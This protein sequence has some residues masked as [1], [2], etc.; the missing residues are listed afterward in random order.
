M[1]T[2]MPDNRDLTIESLEQMVA[3][4]KDTIRSQRDTI[5][6]LQK[7]N[8]V[9][10]EQ[11]EETSKQLES[12]NEQFLTSRGLFNSNENNRSLSIDENSSMPI[13]KDSTF[14]EST[15]AS[16]I[17]GNAQ[18]V[19]VDEDDVYSSGDDVETYKTKIENDHELLPL[20]QG[21]LKK[22][23]EKLHQYNSRYVVLY[24]SFLLYYDECPIKMDARKKRKNSSLNLMKKGGDG[25]ND[26][27]HP[28][29]TIYLRNYH[30]AI[31]K[32]QKKK[33]FDITF[34]P[35]DSAV[36]MGLAASDARIRF[37]CKTLP[38]LIAWTEKIRTAITSA[39]SGFIKYGMIYIS[40]QK[41]FCYPCT[42]NIW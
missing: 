12:S 9:L 27:N 41:C 32:D 1:A 24:P 4:L 30:V 26:I 20:K 3:E 39:N 10:T 16:G 28:K 37:R 7:T 36:N 38:E 18:S 40:I 23:S 5:E 25:N 19:Q 6:A 34:V 35:H 13:R 42:L 33:R 8:Q 15:E 11:L 21:K 17:Y 29:G 14:S 22:K 2:K 31:R